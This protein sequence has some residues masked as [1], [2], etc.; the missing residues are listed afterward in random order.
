[1]ISLI[2]LILPSIVLI[3]AIINFL[4]FYTLA[5]DRGDIYYEFDNALSSK[6]WKLFFVFLGLAFIIF[7]AYKKLN[8]DAL[9]IYSTYF[10]S[11]LE[12]FDEDKFDRL[13]RLLQN[14]SRKE[15]G[16]LRDFRFILDTGIQS[17]VYLI[18]GSSELFSL[19]FTPGI[20]SNGIYVESRFY[21]WDHIREYSINTT[22]TDPELNL[23]M[24]KKAFAYTGSKIITLAIEK[25]DQHEI[26]NYLRH[27]IRKP[28]E[29]ELKLEQIN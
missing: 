17:L 22:K 23:T 18:G 27:E 9:T 11:P 10:Q 26:E 5:S 19:I 13:R 21:N 14:T 3:R 8:F 12:L 16:L 2:A 1:M 7:L 28:T 6:L 4:T 15:Y 29:L 24:K 20:Y 25:S